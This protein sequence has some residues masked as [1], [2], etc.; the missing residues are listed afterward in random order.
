[1]I[2]VCIKCRWLQLEREY[3]GLTVGKHYEVVSTRASYSDWD[4]VADDQYVISNDHGINY[5]YC[6]SYF[7]SLEDFRDKQI[8]GIL[9]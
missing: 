4:I 9:T 8:E 1:M 3:D 6:M 2:V 7:M 5:P